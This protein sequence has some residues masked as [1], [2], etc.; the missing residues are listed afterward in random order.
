MLEW[1]D[2]GYWGLF[3]ASFLAATVLPFSSEAIL[4]AMLVGDYDPVLCLTLAS[5]GNWLGGMT[6]FF[7]GYLGKWQWIEKYLRVK[8]ER[9]EKFKSRVDRYGAY[10]AFLCWLPIIGD[11]LAIG[12]GL[13]R[14]N[15]FK[16]A[17]FMFLGKFLRYLV[18]A[19]IT[20]ELVSF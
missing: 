17:V 19:A 16:V 15:P 9:V 20:M 7:L 8:R 3:L 11:P 13:F 10:L 2:Y 1:L 12:L 4:S 14:A 6:S 5:I 18:L